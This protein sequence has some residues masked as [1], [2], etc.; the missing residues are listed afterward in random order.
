MITRDSAWNL[1]IEYTK[2]DSLQK[3]A[4]AVEVLMRAYARKYGEDEEAWGAV[5][6]LHD[7]DYEMFPQFPDHPTKGSEILRQRGF[8]EELVYAISSHVDMMN[9]ARHNLLC[10]AIFACDELAGFLVASALVRPGKSILGME[11]KSVKKKLKDKAFARSVSRDDI[12]KGALELGVD[13]DEHISFCIRALEE[14]AAL[15]GLDGA[16]GFQN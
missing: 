11:A 15:L 2:T 4:L 13:L 5:G 7:F 3:H 1:L 9:L 16:A 6:L 8:P 12:Y 14:R 10:K